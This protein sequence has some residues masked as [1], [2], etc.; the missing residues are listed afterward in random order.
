M[1]CLGRSCLSL[2]L[3]A[4]LIILGALSRGECMRE[5]RDFK[6][7][8]ESQLAKGPVP[9]SAPSQCHNKLGPYRDNKSSFQDED[10]YVVV[11]HLHDGDDAKT[12]RQDGCG[13]ILDLCLVLMQVS[14]GMMEEISCLEFGGEASL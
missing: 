14:D 6:S 8:F 1:P 2:F 7:T 12:V 13:A 3:V 10:S 9:P 4:V 11:A 5:L